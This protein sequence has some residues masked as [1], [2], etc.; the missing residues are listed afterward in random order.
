MRHAGPAELRDPLHRRRASDE[1]DGDRFVAPRDRQRHG[2]ADAFD[3]TLELGAGELAKVEPVDD[4]VPE[5]HEA[6]PEPIAAAVCLVDV[7][8]RRKRR[9]QA[10][11]RARVDPGSAGELV[12]PQL[13]A[14]R[15]RVHHGERAGDGG[16]LS[17]SLSAC[18]FHAT[19][20]PIVTR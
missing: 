3:E 16:H 10:R 18:G 17:R 15:Q 5:L 6:N 7:T 9:Q 14:G 11:D 19:V 2:L 8:G 4:G 12:R 1:V 13:A 20:S